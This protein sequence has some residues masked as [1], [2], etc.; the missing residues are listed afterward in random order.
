VGAGHACRL[1]SRLRL[2]GPSVCVGEA[3]FADLK[4]KVTV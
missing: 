1:L 2:V 4:A 3:K